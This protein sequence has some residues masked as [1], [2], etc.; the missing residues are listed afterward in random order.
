VHG[1]DVLDERDH[2]TATDL[3]YRMA[4]PGGQN[5]AAEDV[6][7]LLM[8]ARPGSRLRV[9]AQEPLGQRLDAVGGSEDG[10]LRDRRLRLPLLCRRVHPLL[11]LVPRLRSRLARAGEGERVA[12]G[13]LVVGKAAQR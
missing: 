3:V 2:V 8:G 12:A 9:E 4:P 10:Q 7:G 5:E 11:D 13:H 1:C 6:L